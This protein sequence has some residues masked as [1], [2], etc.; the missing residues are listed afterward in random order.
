MNGDIIAIIYGVVLVLFFV[1]L[2]ILTITLI[3]GKDKKKDEEEYDE[4]NEGYEYDLFL[5]EEEV[6]VD[7][8]DKHAKTEIDFDEEEEEDTHS[9]IQHI[10]ADM[11][12]AFSQVDEQPVDIPSNDAIAQSIEDAMKD[13]AF[14]MPDD[15]TDELIGDSAFEQ[16]TQSETTVSHSDFA[17][18]MEDIGLD[19]AVIPEETIEDS[20]TDIPVVEDSAFAAV[21][22]EP[23]A[24][25]SAFVAAQEEPVVEDSAFVAAQEEPVVED[26]A[27]SSF[28]E[29]EIGEKV[30][31]TDEIPTV[32]INASIREA[33]ALGEAMSEPKP[34]YN[35]PKSK[36]GPISKVA[37]TDDFYWFNKADVAEKPSY[38]TED[39]YYH[40]FNIAKD[41][42]EDLI[43]EMYDCALVRTEEIKYI[44]YGIEPRAVSMKE[45]LTS[46][47]RNYVAQTRIKEPTTQDLVKIYETWCGYVDK[48]FDKIHIH[49]DQFT[50]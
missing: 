34:V 36:K 28:A 31:H 2:V 10:M 33:V 12:S 13:S 35:E 47:N 48:L 41:C 3:T 7:P 42:I 14:N 40:H 46:G 49:A 26:S 27:F 6:K 22:E 29:D 20:N 23:V 1:L 44:A 30:F 32:D 5:K 43:M 9:D 45:I 11:D 21:Q 39:M 37:S 38:K 15:P 8:W 17:K 24:E 19:E 16:I 18:A 25:D 50:I 4:E